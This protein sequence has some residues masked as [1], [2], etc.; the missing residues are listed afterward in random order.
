MVKKYVY[1]TFMDVI[2]D[3]G[4]SDIGSVVVFKRKI[5]MTKIK[6][7]K[8]IGTGVCIVLI[9]GFLNPGFRDQC[10]DF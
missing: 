7:Y 5:G 10:F 4:M 6:Q 2:N 3:L 8:Y 9:G 1:A